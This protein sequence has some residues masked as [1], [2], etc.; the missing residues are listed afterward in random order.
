MTRASS[1]GA[2]LRMGPLA[3]LC[4]EMTIGFCV[5][6]VEESAECGQVKGKESTILS[7]SIAKNRSHSAKSD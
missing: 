4:A 3:G 5:P 7:A 6:N 2:V 1:L